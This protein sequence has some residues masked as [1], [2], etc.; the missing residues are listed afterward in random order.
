MVS[1]WVNQSFSRQNERAR[2]RGGL[3]PASAER[4]LR[5]RPAH[6]PFLR[7]PSVRRIASRQRAR[8]LISV[9]VRPSAARHHRAQRVR[10]FCVGTPPPPRAS[11]AFQ[12][13]IF[14]S[15]LKKFVLVIMIISSGREMVKHDLW[16]VQT[17]DDF[18]KLM[19]SSSALMFEVRTT[20]DI[21]FVLRFYEAL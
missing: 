19:S 10:T 20:C 17:R 2:L 18:I 13:C 7:P 8:P 16:N 1:S 11:A 4:R 5:R 3:S 9:R 15:S 12:V 6:H 14:L 21:S